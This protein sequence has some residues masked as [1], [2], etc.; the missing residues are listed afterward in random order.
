[1]FRIPERNKKDTS[2]EE[3]NTIF[4]VDSSFDVDTSSDRQKPMIEMAEREEY[5]EYKD[6][7]VDDNIDELI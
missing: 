7:K 5:D 1:M 3:V 6:D 2:I 4:V